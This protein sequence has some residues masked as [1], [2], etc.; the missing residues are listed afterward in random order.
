[1]L[2]VRSVVEIGPV[3][4]VP[5][6][7][8]ALLGVVN[9]GGRAIALADLAVV[10]GGE[11]LPGRERATALVLEPSESEGEPIAL[12]AEVV[13]VIELGADRIEPTPAFGLGAR[14]SLVAG[15]AHIDGEQLALVL[16]PHQLAAALAVKGAA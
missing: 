5:G 15:V 8:T 1:M 3:T 2:R 9:V 12:L 11:R 13:D 7:P 16:D 6:A 14:T 10:L 4:P